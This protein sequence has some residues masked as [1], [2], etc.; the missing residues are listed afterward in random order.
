MKFCVSLL[1]KMVVCFFDIVMLEVARN[2]WGTK[3]SISFWNACISKWGSCWKMLQQNLVQFSLKNAGRNQEKG[4]KETTLIQKWALIFQGCNA[5]NQFWLVAFWSIVNLG[6]DDPVFFSQDASELTQ[7]I[8]MGKRIL[9]NPLFRPS[10][11]H[12]KKQQIAQKTRKFMWSSCAGG[13]WQEITFFQPLSCTLFRSNDDKKCI[14]DL[15]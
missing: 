2:K 4:L 7:N 11:E 9:G 10:R 3:K 12:L 6:K 8:W 13:I 15:E 1:R 5:S 14:G